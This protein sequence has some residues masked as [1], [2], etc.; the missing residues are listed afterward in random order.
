MST[1][2]A[3][4][5]PTSRPSASADLAD[6]C[7]RFEQ[8][9]LPRKRAST[10]AD[11]RRMLRE[12]ISGRTSA[13][14]QSGGRRLRGHRPLHRKITQAGATYAANRC[15]AVLSKMFSLADPLGHA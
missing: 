3:T 8:E 5:S 7:D 10:A 12:S 9:H 14:T 13:R 11:Y 2:V 4:R 6:L 1:T 15:V